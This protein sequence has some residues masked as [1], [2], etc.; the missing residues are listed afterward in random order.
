MT[1]GIYVFESLFIN[2]KGFEV[3]RRIY[4][5]INKSNKSPNSLG[6]TIYAIEW[7]G[8]VY[9]E[10]QLKYMVFKKCYLLNSAVKELFRISTNGYGFLNRQ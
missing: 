2:I 6:H 5:G 10:N 4:R 8:L 9:L 7:V 1:H 3:Y